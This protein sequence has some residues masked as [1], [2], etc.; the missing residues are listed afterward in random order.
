MSGT[1]SGGAAPESDVVQ[2]RTQLDT[3][4]VQDTDIAAHGGG[5]AFLAVFSTGPAIRGSCVDISQSLVAGVM[6]AW[7]TSRVA[8]SPLAPTTVSCIA[9]KRVSRVVKAVGV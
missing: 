7:V 6:S 5:I 1:E 9:L 4:R 3:T 8:L 2:A